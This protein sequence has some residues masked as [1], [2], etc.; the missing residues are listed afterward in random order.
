MKTAAGLL[1]A[2]SGTVIIATILGLLLGRLTPLIAIVALIAGATTGVCAYL[3][4][5]REKN[6]RPL[7]I[8]GWGAIL[9]FGLF[10]LRAFLWVLYQTE[11]ELRI[12]SPN[13]LGDLSLH[14]TYIHHLANGAPF[15]PENPIFAGASLHYPAGIDIFNALLKL[16]GLDVIRGLVITGLAASAITGWL[17]YRWGGAFAMT[18]FL[19]NG[20]LAGFL[21][22]TNLEWNDYQS[23][24]AWKSFPLSMLVTQRG[25]LYAIPCG[26]LLLH[27]WRERLRRNANL[28][29]DWVQVLLYSTLPLFHLHTFLF[30]SVLLGCWL[31]TEP[32]EIKRELFML[33]TWAFVPATLL[34]LLLTS[35]FQAGSGAHWH[36]GWMQGGQ[37]FFGFW[38]INFGLLPFFI[39]ALLVQLIRQSNNPETR[40]ARRFVFPALAV[41]LACCLVSLSQWEW[42]NTKIMIWSYLVVLPFLWDLLIVRTPRLFQV[43]SCFVL[44]FSGFVSLIGGIDSR[45]GYQLANREELDSLGSAMRQ[46]PA[47]ETIAMQPIYNHPLLLNGHKAVM[48][49][50]GHLWSH[51]VDY[52]DREMEL[53]QLMNG[54]PD[55]QETARKLKVRYLFWGDRERTGYPKS[56]APWRVANRLVFHTPYGDLYDLQTSSD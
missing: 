5:S 18:G 35:G 41:F 37:N 13:N 27:C 15:W 3:K 34:V 36:P 48:G 17:L 44:F 25:L 21:F 46:I 24:L 55:W 7:T 22:F 32:V 10:A 50:P 49:Y 40:L 29:P 54:A 23:D 9:L 8:W 28:V 39:L 26:L 31:F 19:C 33:I 14:L 2:T 56:T 30:L 6:T 43:A 51:G 1:A 16:A 47:S 4:T 53:E 42:D 11:D 38:L 12:L 45:H 20:G 52:Q